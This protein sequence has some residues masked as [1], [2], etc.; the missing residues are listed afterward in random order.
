MLRPAEGN[1][2]RDPQARVLFAGELIQGSLDE[3]DRFVVVSNQSI[4]ETQVLARHGLVR[5]HPEPLPHGE[6]SFIL[7]ESAL[8]ISGALE[9]QTDVVERRGLSLSVCRGLR[10]AECAL[11]RR[12][13]SSRIAKFPPRRA[14]LVQ[15]LRFA[16]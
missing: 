14:D 11:I 1:Q 7:D 4:E 10:E 5:L 3:V 16:G 8:K 12:E 6:G 9:G 13:G 15:D 2:S